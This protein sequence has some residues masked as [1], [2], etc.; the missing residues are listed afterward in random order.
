MKPDFDWKKKDAIGNSLLDWGHIWIVPE[1]RLQSHVADPILAARILTPDGRA[2]NVPGVI[3]A[4]WNGPLLLEVQWDGPAP[5]D[6]P[7]V[8]TPDL[9][10]PTVLITRAGGRSIE[11]EVL[12]RGRINASVRSILEPRALDIV[13]YLREFVCV[14]STGAIT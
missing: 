4:A 14:S 6:L 2:H 9:D 12:D 8:S 1:R 13:R 10:Q 7:V 5:P 3:A 11:A